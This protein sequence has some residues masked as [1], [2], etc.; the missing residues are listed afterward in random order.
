MCLFS[1]ALS[2]VVYLQKQQRTNSMSSFPFSVRELLTAGM[3]NLSLKDVGCREKKHGQSCFLRTWLTG[4]FF[5]AARCPH[6]AGL[7]TFKRFLYNVIQIMLFSLSLEEYLKEKKR[8]K[9]IYIVWLPTG[10]DS[11]SRTYLIQQKRSVLM[12]YASVSKNWAESALG[13]KRQDRTPGTPIP[14]S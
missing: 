7:A 1:F 3:K 14:T 10:K 8:R 11:N 2:P 6:G 4:W 5:R 12:K 13:S 9:T